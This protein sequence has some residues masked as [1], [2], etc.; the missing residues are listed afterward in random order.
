MVNS[1]FQVTGAGSGIDWGGMIDKIMENARKIEKPWK[2]EKEKLELKIGL[3]EELSG[4]LKQL[5]KILTSLKLP[6]EYN[7]KTAVFSV[8]SPAGAKAESILTATPTSE[9]VI[10]EWDLDVLNTA[11]AE[12]RISNYYSSATTA[13]GL[14]GSFAIRVGGQRATI[15]V[16]TSDTLRDIN[17]K[18]Q[19]AVDSGNNRL[20]ISAQLV[21]NRIVLSSANSGLG[22]ASATGATMRRGTWSAATGGDDYLPHKMDVAY[23]KGTGSTDQITPL[24]SGQYPSTISIEGKTATTDYTYDNSTGTISWVAGHE[25]ATGTDFKVTY[26]GGYPD[27]IAEIKSGST[28][29]TS[30]TDFTY[31]GATGKIHW[32]A[33]ANHPAEGASYEITFKSTLNKTKGSAEGTD[34][35]TRPSSGVFP[36]TIVVKSGSTTYTADTDYHWDP[37]TGTIDWSLGGGEPPTGSSYTVTFG[38]EYTYAANPFYLE[39]ETGGVLSSLG[40]AGNLGSSYS[41]AT[42]ANLLLNGV[43]VTRAS[44]TI[45]DLVGNTTLNLKGAGHVTMSVEADAEK[46]VA[47][48]QSFVELYNDVME[49]INVRISEESKKTSK[50]N[51]NKSDDFNKKF[52]LLHGD[53]LLWQTKARMRQLI[54]DPLNIAG[55]LR[56]LSQ[57]GI[58]TEKANYGKSGKLEFDTQLFM[59]ALTPGKMSFMDEWMTDQKT[60]ATESLG[61]IVAGFTGGNFSITQDGRTATVNITTDDSL[62]SMAQ[63][64]NDARTE[65]GQ[66][67]GVSASVIDRKL[68]IRSTKMGKELSFT[69]GNAVL[70]KL[71]IDVTNPQ[72]RTHRVLDTPPYVGELMTKAMTQLDAYMDNLVKSTQVQVGPTTAPQGRVASQI[73]YLKNQVAAIDLRVKNYEIRMD[74]MEQGLWTRFTT[75]E[76]ALTKVNAQASALASAFASLSG[77]SKASSQ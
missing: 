66:S 21:N 36:P 35:L 48:V 73:L 71:G 29:Y 19:Q 75:M 47:D 68:V 62:T 28:T 40:L 22:S 38:R 58:A 25:P 56:S 34:T 30:G 7:K 8:L 50:S 63:K 3:Y 37:V 14:S 10:Q 76:K 33:G 24:T 18:I 49:W 27:Y 44:N 4:G 64:I 45:T 43:P 1:M 46:A 17:Y 39:D 65:D 20:N 74:L 11:T 13:L 52:G 31:D 41:K 61:K 2:E 69:D 53:S 72:D 32:N 57:V 26:E 16:A 42:D 9:A 54:S 59:D 55:P 51:S 5:Q 70:K 60:S 77:A 67:I 15:A 23:T 12:R 6:S